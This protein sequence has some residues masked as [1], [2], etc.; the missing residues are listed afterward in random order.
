[1]APQPLLII[2]SG[3]GIALSTALHF[4][5]QNF[6]H[7][8]LVA[9]TQANL[10]TTAATITDAHPTVS[11]STYACDVSDTL[12]LTS[13]LTTITRTSGYPSVILFN[14][15]NVSPSPDLSASTLSPLAVS[16]RLISDFAT[17]TTALYVVASTLLPHMLTL[18]KP[19]LL[20]TGG[21]IH[22]TPFPPFF[23]LSASKAAQ[24][25]LAGSLAAVYGPMG[26]HV[27]MVVVNGLVAQEGE[28]SA[29]SI[30]REIWEVYEKGVEAGREGKMSVRE[31]GRVEDFLRMV[32]QA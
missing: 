11:V 31:V 19:T 10:N 7:I 28:M 15:A 12:A 5:S 8:I 4:A 18:P 9:R 3:P 24:F 20:L 30:A 16:T 1:M 27:G 2:G 17:T 22:H 6:T 13:T 25:N 21:H 26:V 14:A 29:E 32:G 23:S